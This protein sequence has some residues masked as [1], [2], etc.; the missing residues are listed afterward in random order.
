MTLSVTCKPVRI[1][2]FSPQS[3]PD[4]GAH[5]RKGDWL[6]EID[7]PEVDQQLDQAKADLV[8]ATANANLAAVTASRFKTLAKDQWASEQGADDKTLPRPRR[9]RRWTRPPPT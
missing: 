3:R 4:I 9:R 5:V 7:T 6:A 2:T 1:S 8:N